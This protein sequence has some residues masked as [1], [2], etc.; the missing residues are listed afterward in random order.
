MPRLSGSHMLLAL[1]GLEESKS[2]KW[3][4]WC[5]DLTVARDAWIV[6]LLL[7][8]GTSTTHRESV[9]VLGQ[10]FSNLQAFLGHDVFIFIS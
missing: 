9:N 7:L 5:S 4:F 10:H 2:M 1:C 3:R 8:E 6:H